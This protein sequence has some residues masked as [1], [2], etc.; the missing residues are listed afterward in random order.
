MGGSALHLCGSKQ[1]CTPCEAGRCQADE[2]PI[3]RFGRTRTR[4]Q[5]D[6]DLLVYIGIAMVPIHSLWTID[7]YSHQDT[8]TNVRDL[9]GT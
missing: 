5:G 1:N 6:L 9:L 7:L 2:R 4:S 8:N 3:N